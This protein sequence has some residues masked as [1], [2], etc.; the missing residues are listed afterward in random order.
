[1]ESRKFCDIAEEFWIE[2]IA[3][4][5]TATEKTDRLE[6]L[7]DKAIQRDNIKILQANGTIVIA[8]SIVEA[9]EEVSKRGQIMPA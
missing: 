9:W 2:F 3:V 6:K 1:M 8:Q 7:V 4:S 5:K